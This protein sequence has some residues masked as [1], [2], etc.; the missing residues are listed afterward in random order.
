MTEPTPREFLTYLMPFL[1]TAG[2]YA[3]EIQRRVGRR[4]D[5]AGETPF[6]HALSDADLSIQAYLEV[7]LLARFPQ[8]S[9]FS[10]EQA[11][12]LN[13]K[14]FAVEA[15]YEVLLDPVDG[16]R[17]YIDGRKEFQII[18]TL[19]DKESICA[20]AAYQPRLSRCYAAL[21][22]EGAFI[23]SDEAMRGGKEWERFT[24]AGG[25]NRFLI[26]GD[27]EVEAK[28]GKEFSVTDL[29]RSYGVDPEYVP[30]TSIFESR[31]CGYSFRPG[32]FIDAIALGFIAQEAGGVM[33]DF[34]GRPISSARRYP[35]RK[36][37]AVLVAADKTLHA[38][39]VELL[40]D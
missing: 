33:S 34:Q 27:K 10:E 40:K 31:I 14:Y 38:R 1:Y 9:Y 16:T 7:A 20:V 29:L 30:F 23:I 2:K 5:K 15:H 21:R 6:H 24:I 4:K 35:D 26:F 28:L 11:D 36:A 8:V 22:G 18:V 32:Q 25:T 13:A 37:P 39:L 12:S 19:H 3:A 17:P